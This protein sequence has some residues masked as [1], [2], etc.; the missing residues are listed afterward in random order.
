LGFKT[1]ETLS[2]SRMHLFDIKS[3]VKVKQ[4]GRHWPEP[5]IE[6]EKAK[7]LHFFSKLLRMCL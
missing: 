2:M 5:F 1:S 3:K 7:Q 4:I 6:L